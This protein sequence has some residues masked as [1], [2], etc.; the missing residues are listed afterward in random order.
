MVRAYILPL[1][2]GG[3]A[4]HRFPKYFPYPH[5][6]GWSLMDYGKQ[7][8]ALVIADINETTDNILRSASDVFC[9]PSN[10]DQKI[11]DKQ[12]SSVILK[13]HNLDIPA[14]R[15]TTSHTWRDVIRVVWK[16]FKL[17]CVHHAINNEKVFHSDIKL[18]SRFSSHNSVVKKNFIKSAHNL[19]LDTSSISDSFTLRQALNVLVDQISPEGFELHGEKF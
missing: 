4:N 17:G 9:F 16:T 11:P 2:L 15:F 19:N 6:F 1:I 10:L 13:L 18:D 3:R 5:Q 12:L 7:D 14:D 8:L